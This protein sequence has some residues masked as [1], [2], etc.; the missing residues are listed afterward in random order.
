MIAL[1][2]TANTVL[3]MLIASSRITYGMAKSGSLPL[4]LSRVHHTRRTPVIAIAAITA[5]SLAFLGLGDIRVIAQVTNFTLYVTFLVINATVIIL[6]FRSPDLPRPFRIPLAI[7][8][9]PV[10]PVLG[11]LVCIFFILQLDLFTLFMGVVLLA[12]ATAGSLLLQKRS[13]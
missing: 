8:G 4:H 13:K 11:V 7:R 2:A 5:V 10:F 12:L 1:F 9:V 3:L 6:R